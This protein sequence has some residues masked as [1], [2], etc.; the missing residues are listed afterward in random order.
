MVRALAK[1]KAMTEERKME[2]IVSLVPVAFSL[3]MLMAS[4]A[5]YSAQ[6]GRSGLGWLVSQ[7]KVLQDS[8]KVLGLV[9]FLSLE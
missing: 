5:E 3:Y 2:D 9:F 4:V 8:L 6:L 7:G 1:G